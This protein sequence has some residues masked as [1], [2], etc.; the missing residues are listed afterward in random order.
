MKLSTI[1]D[2][3]HINVVCI[4]KLDLEVDDRQH[5]GEIDIQEKRKA[6]RKDHRKD[7][8]K[9]KRRTT[10]D[11]KNE[12]E[13]MDVRCVLSR[14]QQIVIVYERAMKSTMEMRE[15]KSRMMCR[16]SISS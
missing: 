15:A 11:G 9:D 4:Q 14:K 2:Y 5:W 8:I 13:A 12:R 16:A 6:R 3:H 7:N 1:F 10:R